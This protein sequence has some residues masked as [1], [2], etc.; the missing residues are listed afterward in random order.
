MDCLGVP[1]LPGE[2]GA[3]WPLWFQAQGVS[4]DTAQYGTAFDDGFLTVK[5]AIRGHGLA[6]V[7]D[8]YV[9]DELA[10]GTLIQ[11]LPGSWPTKFAYYA[12]ARTES[13]DRPSIKA[14]IAW[15]KGAVI[16]PE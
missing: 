12:V 9:R 6:L 16:T 15:L 1:L 4:A 14:F 7:N 8:I 10:D 11:V 5:A 2:T 13:S 3:D